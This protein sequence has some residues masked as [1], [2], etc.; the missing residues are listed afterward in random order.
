MTPTKDDFEKP[1]N[2][3]VY[4]DTIDDLLENVLDTDR[5][6]AMNCMTEE[7]QEGWKYIKN[8]ILKNQQK[9]NW[10]DNFVS[11]FPNVDFKRLEYL[12]VKEVGKEV[13]VHR[14]G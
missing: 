8:Q 14:F 11:N 5:I 6:S 9:A 2:I 7:L 12:A 4:L 10:W 3:R 13:E 1:E